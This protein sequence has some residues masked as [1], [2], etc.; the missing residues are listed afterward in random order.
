MPNLNLT[1]WRINSLYFN[2]DN[3]ER[4]GNDLK[5]VLSFSTII[6]EN[7]TENVERA[8]IEFKAKTKED[9]IFIKVELDAIFHFT[10]ENLTREQKESLLNTEG[11]PE[12]YEK[13]RVFLNEF[14]DHSHVKRLV[15]P[16][17]SEFVS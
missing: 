3:L 7:D 16:E 14:M 11:C 10:E 12:V 17:Y 13:M 6:P 2:M 8:R 1:K 15:L 9:N 5:L 4:G